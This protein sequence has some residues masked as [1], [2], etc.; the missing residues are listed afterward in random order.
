MEE[1]KRGVLCAGF[2]SLVHRTVSLSRSEET[3]LEGR[4]VYCKD[5]AGNFCEEYEGPRRKLRCAK[6]SRT[7]PQFLQ[8]VEIFLQSVSNQDEVVGCRLRVRRRK[9][10]DC[11]LY[12][13]GQVVP[14]DNLTVIELMRSLEHERVRSDYHHRP[15]R[16]LNRRYRLVTLAPDTQDMRRTHNP[17]KRI[18]VRDLAYV[19]FNNVVTAPGA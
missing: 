4:C 8:A 1:R 2:T 15:H 3:S 10:A 16:I 9:T 19:F 6:M 17:W 18:C 14:W 11:G 13:S 12:C 7:D 5:I